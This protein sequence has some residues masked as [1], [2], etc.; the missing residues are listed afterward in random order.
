M[1][2]LIVSATPFEIAP[3]QSI[4]GIP[5]IINNKL[6]RYNKNNT[7]IDILITGVG[8]VFTTFHLSSLLTIEKYNLA[9]NAGVAGAIDKHLKLGEV[10]HV[11]SDFFYELGA[12]Q[13][14]QW[15]SI[16]DLGLL[17]ESDWP[18]TKTGLEN[19]HELLYPFIKQLRQ[20]SGHTVNKIHGNEE[21][22]KTMQKRSAAQ[23]ESMEG[24]AFL[25]CCLQHQIP[26]AQI[27]AISNYVALRNKSNWKMQEAIT[28][29]NNFLK[30]NLA[31]L[32]Q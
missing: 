15:L 8:M 7:Q 25:Y 18:Y 9:I 29:L 19:K 22:I 30:T 1:K 11:V 26:C 10:V 21:S 12:E 23:V 3:F 6:T 13:D 17:S 14:N 20:V 28:H 16:D 32:F 27:R 4:L 24:A 2:I 5:I 31:A